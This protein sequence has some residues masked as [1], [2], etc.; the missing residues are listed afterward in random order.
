[1]FAGWG[2]VRGIFYLIGV[3]FVRC[4]LHFT[5]HLVTLR[6][7]LPFSSLNGGGHSKIVKLGVENS[8]RFPAVPLVLAPSHSV[9][10][11][12]LKGAAISQL[13]K[14]CCVVRGALPC[15]NFK[16]K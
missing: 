5:A 1:M 2:L 16:L 9:F 4:D 13:L 10:F 15:V 14:V 12:T 6:S 11:E 3:G 8:A 7:M